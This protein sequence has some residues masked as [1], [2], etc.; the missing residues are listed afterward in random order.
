MPCTDVHNI[1]VYNLINKVILACV[2]LSVCVRVSVFVCEYECVC[3]HVYVC[4][5]ACVCCT[6]ATDISKVMTIRC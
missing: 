6:R 3:V 4:V 1:Q 5:H 2:C